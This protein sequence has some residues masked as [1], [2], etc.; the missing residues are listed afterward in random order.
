[1]TV[2]IALGLSCA[3]VI[4]AAP[5]KRLQFLFKNGLDR[6]ADILS[7]AIFDGII[8]GFIGK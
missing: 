1:M 8:A 4:A 6:G 2:P 7:Q 3:A 5:Q